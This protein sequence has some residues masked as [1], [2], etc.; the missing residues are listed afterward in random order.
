MM[1][2]QWMIGLVG[3]DAMSISSA[4]RIQQNY[5]LR[6]TLFFDVWPSTTKLELNPK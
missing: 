2:S 5:T 4:S 6:V 1:T 3:I